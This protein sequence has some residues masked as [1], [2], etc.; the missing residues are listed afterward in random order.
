MPSLL[1]TRP[2]HDLPTTYLFY[3]SKLVIDFARRKKITVYDLAGKK[4]DLKNFQSYMQ[5]NNPNLVFFN[6]HGSAEEITGMNNKV[7][8]GIDKSQELLKD[9]LIYAR[10]CDCGSML[11][12]V[13]I[14]N[15]TKVFIGYRKKFSLAYLDN[16]KTRPLQGIV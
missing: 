5:K 9:K 8:V 15:G 16:R 6:G 10:S 14:K 12:K 1:V 3:W 13:C 7:L 2:N 4:A 11:G